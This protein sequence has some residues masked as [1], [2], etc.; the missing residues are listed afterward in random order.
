MFLLWQQADNSSSIQKNSSLFWQ[1]KNY[2]TYSNTWGK[3][4]VTAMLG[5]E[6]WE[7][8]YDYMSLLNTSL[9]LNEIHNPMLGTG[10]KT[11]NYGFGSSA[12]ASFFT[13]FAITTI[14]VTFSITI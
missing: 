13:C 6:M 4:S 1:L 2:I 5:Q 8:S 14:F 3:H 12:M 10:E 11:P 7:S 9:P